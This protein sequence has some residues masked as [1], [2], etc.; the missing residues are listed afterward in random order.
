MPIE[1]FTSSYWVVREC[2]CNHRTEVTFLTTDYTDFTDST[3]E[4]RRHS[5]KANRFCRISDPER[6]WMDAQCD[7]G[8]GTLVLK[9]S[10]P[11]MPTMVMI[12]SIM[13][14]RGAISKPASQRRVFA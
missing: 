8:S 13:K 10:T 14:T 11:N 9:R 2:A 5:P 3:E 12:P 4:A 6:G 1:R 7:Q